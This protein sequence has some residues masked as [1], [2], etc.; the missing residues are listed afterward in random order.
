MRWASGAVLRQS[1]EMLMTTWFASPM[2]QDRMLGPHLAIVPSMV[3]PRSGY[4]RVLVY[5]NGVPGCCRRFLSSSSR[6][7]TKGGYLEEG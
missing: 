3:K 7:A 2:V 4:R 6:R 1:T 5:R